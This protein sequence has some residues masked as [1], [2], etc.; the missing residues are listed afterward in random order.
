LKILQRIHCSRLR[1][2]AVGILCAI[3]AWLLTRSSLLENVENWFQD[4]CFVFR[5]KVD[6]GRSN[7]VLVNVDEQSL[8]EI[9]KPL[10]FLSAELAETVT[11]LKKQG[12]LAVGLDLM[13]PEGCFGMLEKQDVGAKGVSNA[14]ILGKAIDAAK[15]VVLPET[16]GK[17]GWN[18]PTAQWRSRLERDLVDDPA[19]ARI[20]IGFCDLSQ[21]PDFF[22]R[23]QVL[24]DVDGEN[25][26]FALAL[27]ARA[28]T[29]K[30]DV[31]GGIVRLNNDPVPMDRG[32][33]VINFFGPPGTFPSVSLRDV[34]AA[35]RG[36]KPAP[37]NFANSIV[38]VGLSAR[39]QQ[40]YHATPFAN[41]YWGS[42]FG[43][44][45]LTSGPEIHANIAAT[46]LER[47]Y[48]RT[49]PAWL[50][51]AF[52]LLVGA[53]LGHLFARAGVALGILLAVTQHFGWKALCLV[54]FAALSLRLELLPMLTL[55]AFVWAAT[56]LQRW[57][58]LRRMLGVVKS[59]TIAN[60]LES[61]PEL[62]D[63]RGEERIV[64]VLFADI[65][66][67]T[68]YSEK[69]AAREVVTLLNRY[70]T[71]IVDL[72]EQNGGTLNQYMG[73]GIMVLFG[74]PVRHPDHALQAVR[75]ARAIVQRVHDR[76]ALW[77]DLGFP[78]MRIGVGVH[79]GPVIAGTVGSLRRLD[80]SAIGD[81]VNAAS[82]IEA[83]N[84]KFGTEILISS[85]TYREIPD[86]ERALVG[87][88]P[89]SFPTEVKGRQQSLDLH[90]VVLEANE[91]STRPASPVS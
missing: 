66:G 36:T 88:K 65:R 37:C 1:G 61:D 9:S 48:V 53:I 39:D 84:K 77:A 6:P 40:D 82:R 7:V 59:E 55:G 43:P 80:Y 4:G 8:R 5:G 47:A 44:S 72:I 10:A 69:H 17:E 87:C 46:L 67:F 49:P 52:L 35:A 85:A 71:E 31:Q 78:G 3:A 64:T 56:F 24:A 38:I 73:D 20:D 26:Q 22:V 16:L 76:Q 28:R 32:E 51:F 91:A 89:A 13:V 58:L 63:L 21:D 42:W 45:D 15:N 25:L 23:R 50:S 11:Y 83:E 54:L 14:T 33:L 30:V 57:L 75:A 62:L 12:A 86:R 29:W 81:T 2:A 34:L 79:T 27:V 70:Y 19:E 41:N 90:E 68:V 74:A 18:R 60:L